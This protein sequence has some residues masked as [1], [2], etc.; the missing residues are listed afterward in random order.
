M[1]EFPQVI[2]AQ[3]RQ[4]KNSVNRMRKISAT[5]LTACL[6]SIML[7][8]VQAIPFVLSQIQ[9]DLTYELNCEVNSTTPLWAP[10]THTFEMTCQGQL[11]TPFLDTFTMNGS[12]TLTYT[13]VGGGF[14]PGELDLTMD[15][16][17]YLNNSFW[18]GPYTLSAQSHGETVLVATTPSFIRT[19]EL[20][21]FAANGTFDG[22]LWNVTGD[23]A[24]VDFSY[25]HEL[26]T[27]FQIRVTGLG[28]TSIIP[29]L[30]SLILLPL[31][32][33]AT[34]IAALVYRRKQT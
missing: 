27:S 20:Q 28:H 2:K 8:A 32:M 23:T 3:P 19:E 4:M 21:T 6:F 29:E 18:N 11:Q 13:M 1:R 25:I 24:I 16:T 31:F 26:G 10:G 12:G 5:L 7:F 14:P 17:G 9:L 34:L 30:P 15:M 22:W 33:T